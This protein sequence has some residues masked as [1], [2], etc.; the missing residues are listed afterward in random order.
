MTIRSQGRRK[1]TFPADTGIPSDAYL[2]FVAGGANYRISLANFLSALNVTG[3]IVQSG[4]TTAVP[5][6]DPQGTVNKIRNLEASST[7]G[8][9]AS[10]SALNG[11]TITLDAQVPDGTG[12]KILDDTNH[13]RRLLA[14]TGIGLAVVDGD[15]VVTASGGAGSIGF[16]SFDTDVSDTMKFADCST[17]DT[18]TVAVSSNG[19]VAQLSIEKTGGGDLR[20]LFGTGLYVWDTSPAATVALTPGTDTAPQMNFVYFLESTKTLTVSTSDWPTGEYFP[21]ATVFCQSAANVQTDGVYKFHAWIDHMSSSN[22]QGHLS[23]LNHWIRHQ[24]ATWLDGVALTPT[25]TINGA[26][27]DN[28]DVATTIGELLQLH[29]H[30]YPAFDTSTGSH[31]H[32][33][34][35]S[36]AAYDQI[37]D[38][39]A[40]DEDDA[41]NA[42]G[43]NDWTN[44]VIWGVVN[45]TAA[46]CKLMVNLPSGFHA[47]AATAVADLAA[48]SNYT[49]PDEYRGVGFLIAR[50]TLKYSTGS[51]GTWTLE[52]NLDLRGG[53]V[54]GGSGTSSAIIQGVGTPEGVVTAPV[55]TLFLRSDGGAGTSL[56]VKESGTGNTGWIGK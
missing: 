21:I 43:N 19:T 35:K 24:P 36:G 6:L 10:V 3:T 42:I 31:L 50:L 15:I 20:L 8:L 2:D 11:I 53:G 48:Y 41:G 39:N 1:S 51:A 40:A 34:N 23:H 26:L 38:L 29:H 22:G 12:I 56:Y 18:P 16:S 33:I 13:I 28:V 27:E 47:S 54:S 55:G 4:D 5:I 52:E 25:I 17:L 44:I 30:E 45:E 46:D 9:K 14:G 37:T 32:I 7:S 49:I